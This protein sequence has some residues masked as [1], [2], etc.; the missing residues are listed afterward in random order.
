MKSSHMRTLL[1]AIPRPLRHAVLR[2]ML[3]LPS[4]LPPGLEL[5]IATGPD[6]L[7]RALA[8]LHDA[9]V[10]AGFM[11]PHRSGLRVTPWHLLPSTATAI[12]RWEG[13][14]VAT[15]SSIRDG[16]LGLPMDKAFDLSALRARGERIAEISALAI[17]PA[18]RRQRRSL[19]H[20]LIRFLWRY[21]LTH[22]G[23]DRV[24]IL[25]NPSMVELYEAIYLF[26]KLEGRSRIDR[27]DFVKGAPGIALQTPLREGLA[28]IEETYRAR[29]AES[30][31]GAF[32]SA[33]P[34]ANER[35]APRRYYTLDEPRDH[36][37]LLERFLAPRTGLLRDLSP[38]EL[39]ALAQSHQSRGAEH[40]FGGLA[41]S[42]SPRRSARFDVAC[43]VESIGDRI[44]PP[45]TTIRDVSAHGIGV[46]FAPGIPLPARLDEG[47]GLSVAVGPGR[48][49]TVHARRVWQSGE[50][51]AGFE[52][53]SG[54]R[55]W[56]AFQSHLLEAARP[57]PV[58]ST[59]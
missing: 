32:M 15:M 58:R 37:A 20:P 38:A 19:I 26:R 16:A 35:Y 12:A 59:A 57:E 54:C 46:D 24:V 31:L 40:L 53:V 21:S 17:D 45:R 11:D 34:A 44:G 49:A 33:A 1:G 18:F 22:H 55:E 5:E 3:R 51:R 52:V 4:E 23:T 39:S 14:V 9:Y 41:L 2:R 28:E 10:E 13:R 50:R 30:N 48:R 43:P 7:E 47:V 42:R 25:V 27:Y 8:V 6:D 56:R 36:A 29:P